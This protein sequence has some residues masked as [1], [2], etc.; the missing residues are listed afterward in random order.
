MILVNRENMTNPLA[1]YL[2][3]SREELKKVTWPKR[4]EL[5]RLTLVVLG[6]STVTAVYLGVL[7]SILS[8]LVT[9]VI[10]LRK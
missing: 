9:L 4:D 8:R 1:Q 7:D 5:V 3:E 2:T 6:L 10:S